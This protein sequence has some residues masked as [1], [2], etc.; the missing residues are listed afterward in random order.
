M[1]I[2]VRLPSDTEEYV[3]NGSVSKTDPAATLSDI[4]NKAG[5]FHPITVPQSTN[6]GTLGA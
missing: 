1:A 2:V 5:P 3:D 6:Y 4:A